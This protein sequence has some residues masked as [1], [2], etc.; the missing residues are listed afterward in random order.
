MGLQRH[1]AEQHRGRT[2]HETILI[3]LG[4]YVLCAGIVSLL[5][6]VLDFQR[7]ADWFG[8]G[9]AIQPNTTVA[10]IAAGAALTLVGFGRT[11]AVTLPG[12]IVGG[13]GVAT[14][15]Q[16]LT[17]L[18]L[19]ID[20]LLTFDRSWGSSGTLSPGR[21]GIPSSC[22][23]TLAGAAFLLLRAGVGGRRTAA[24]YGLMVMA[25]AS[26]SLVGYIF[27]ADLL[28]SLPSLTTIALQTSTILFGVGAGLIVAV[29]E[30]QPMRGLIDAGAAGLVTR[31]TLPLVIGLPLF[32]GVAWLRGYQLGWYDAPMAMALMALTLIAFQGALLWWN[33]AIIRSHEVAAE[34]ANRRL[35][36]SVL[37]LEALFRAAPIGIAVARNP[38][39]NDIRVNA[40]FAAML[41]IEEHRN[42][43]LSAPGSDHL[44]YRIYE[45]DG[46][47]LDPAEMPIQQSAR[48]GKPVRDR[49][50]LVR[51]EHGKPLI[52]AGSAVPLF[53]PDGA[54]SGSVGVFFDVTAEQEVAAERERLLAANEMARADAEKANRMK[55]EFLAVLSHELRSPLNAMLG[56]VGILK[57]AGTTESM[58]HRAVETLERN[59]RAQTQ[60]INDL[61]DVSRITSGK[62]V[63][64][65]SRVDLV[66]VVLGVVDSLRPIAAGKSLELTLDL[67]PEPLEVEADAARLHQIVGNL[68]HNAIKFTGDNGHVTVCVRREGPEAVV[69]VIDDGQGIDTDML[70]RVF[71][72]FVQ[73]E[74]SSTR[75]HGGLGLGL[76]IVKELTQL[77][78]G[79]VAAASDGPGRG[80]RF[81]VHLPLALP[82]LATRT[83][84][85]RPSKAQAPLDLTSLDILLVDDDE[86]S[87][88]ALGVA[89]AESG[90]R[91]RLASSVD[92]AQAAYG[93]R[94]PDVLIS[95]IAM[96]GKDG[97]LLVRWVREQEKGLER[98]TL[99]IA[100]T[101]FAS[102]QDHDLA[103]QAGFDD[104]LGK[105]VLAEELLERMR[106]LTS[107][108]PASRG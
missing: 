24:V 29:P 37:E 9:I 36:A 12:L 105:P 2:Q 104:H 94:P 108:G 62:L 77:H 67:P 81:V 70:S 16:H 28:Y 18:D 93:A 97:Y 75:R 65:L 47:E 58:V 82:S 71:D 80:A 51:R 7:L 101:G 5:G 68:M 59:I 102:R 55:D 86:D 78:G 8:K 46:R 25:T 19:G 90:A 48:S 100:T 49:L 40:A 30:H 99:A 43:S 26:L 38:H 50:L 63:L 4:L 21:M 45:P 76:A 14:L 87:R 42:A 11:A 57:R 31:R 89:L 33:A 88:E 35:E 64:E 54:S 96:P 61:L 34:G 56:W 83:D 32:V 15:L 53:S 22:S 107:P 95:D 44:P 20:T 79:S 6:W 72:R 98:R 3:G 41:G 27:E 92:E 74:S 23:W 106:G 60:I 39:G 66:P 13:I 52:L 84:R 103:M 91:V 73:S 17:D 69:E 1:A 10:A 85:V